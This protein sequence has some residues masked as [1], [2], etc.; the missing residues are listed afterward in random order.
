MALFRFGSSHFYAVVNGEGAQGD[1]HVMDPDGN[2]A[3][4]IEIVAPQGVGDRLIIA[5]DQEE[6]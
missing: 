2:D 4:V 5:A 6:R 3:D 1:A